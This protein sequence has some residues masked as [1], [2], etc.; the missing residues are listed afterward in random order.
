MLSATRA[1]SEWRPLPCACRLK[2]A[3]TEGL[4]RNH[5]KVQLAALDLFA[6]TFHFGGEAFEESTTALLPQVLAMGSS[7]NHQMQSKAVALRE[8]LGR[9]LSADSLVDAINSALV[10]VRCC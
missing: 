2:V 6:T 8:D 9:R 3:L 5:S 7:R 10:V 1:A 4:E